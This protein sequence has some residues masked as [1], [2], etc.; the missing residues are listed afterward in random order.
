MAIDEHGR[1]PTFNEVS[2]LAYYLNLT[3][4]L[5]I[6]DEVSVTNLIDS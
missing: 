3:P 4:R 5:Q 2:H 1:E 6:L